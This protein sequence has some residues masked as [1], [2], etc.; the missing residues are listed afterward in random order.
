M[1]LNLNE[2]DDLPS[3]SDISTGTTLVLPLNNKVN[4]NQ[5]KPIHILSTVEKHS[6]I[7]CLNEQWLAEDELNHINENT[8]EEPAKVKS[9]KQRSFICN[10]CGKQFQT[11]NEI[12][13]HM[14]Q[15]HESFKPFECS[16]CQMSFFDLSSKKRHEKEHSGFKPFRCLIC[17]FE[18]TRASNLRAHLI[19][20]H[21]SDIGRSV[22]ITKSIDNKLKFEF[23]L[24]RSI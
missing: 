5:M 11:P 15:E 9:K 6:Q 3:E 8:D 13:K 14:L 7:E 2:L 12:S 22:K 23:D 10:E 4:L 19:K 24:G 17:S 21:P 1:I 20:V 18:F 16:Q